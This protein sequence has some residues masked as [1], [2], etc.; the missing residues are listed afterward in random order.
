E[1][2]W[3]KRQAPL[4]VAGVALWI[5]TVGLTAAVAA[6]TLHWIPRP[7]IYVYWIYSLLAVRDLDSHAMRVVTAL[8]QGNLAEARTRLS[9]IVG[10]DTHH[11]DE[12]EIAR[13][14]VETV[15]E[16]LSDGIVAPLFYLALGGPALMAAYKAVN[17]LDSMVG[18][19]N[20]RYRDFG[21]FSARADDWANLIPARL[22]A[23]LICLIA[24]ILPGY[25]AREAIRI[26][27][28][29]GSSQPSPNAGY[30]EAAMAGALGV[31]LGGANRY[32]GVVSSKAHLGDAR[33]ALNARTCRR[34]RA[35]LFGVA[36]IAAVGACLR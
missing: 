17:T 24:A 32:N 3:R 29:D 13:A 28:R 20:E 11:L 21:W 6:T 26:A 5:G 2:W 33:N 4:R 34:A 14:V 19:K 30:P 16:N 18:Y 7:W 12:P 15:S 35:V 23:L 22:T 27:M 9:W 36:L 1:R 25:S 10:R 31:R 8:E